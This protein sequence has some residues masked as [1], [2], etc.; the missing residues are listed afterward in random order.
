MRLFGRLLMLSVWTPGP[1]EWMCTQRAVPCETSHM[2]L[3]P[4][5]QSSQKAL[6][7]LGFHVIC[8]VSGY[9][10]K[11][12]WDKSGYRKQA[13]WSFSELLEHMFPDR[14][15]CKASFIYQ[16]CA[17]MVKLVCGCFDRW[18]L[19]MKGGR[20]DSCVFPSAQLTESLWNE[21]Q[22]MTTFFTQKQPLFH[23]YFF[24]SPC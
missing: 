13:Y 5:K 14:S 2:H 18:L 10:Q 9:V 12:Q 19:R 4:E 17:Q 23:F 20:A 6:G 8:V 1:G 22:H 15:W 16:I 11:K 7:L 3:D 21:N 24:S